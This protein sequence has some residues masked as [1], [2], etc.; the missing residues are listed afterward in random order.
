MTQPA[1]AHPPPH[2]F[3]GRGPARIAKRLFF[4]SRPKFFPASILPVLAGSAWGF[5]ASGSFDG[6]VFAMALAATVC[7]HA[8]ANVLNDVGDDSGGTDRI[9]T[10]RIYPYTGGSRFIQSGILSARDMLRLGAGLL[11]A[12]A[13]LGIGLL[14]L[15]GATVLWFGLAGMLLAVLYSLGPVRLNATGFGEAVVAL[16]FGVIPVTGAA[17]LQSGVVDLPVLL[18]SLPVALW[19]GAILLINEVP[20]RRADGLS[21]KRTLPVRMGLKGTAILY[22]ALQVAAAVPVLWLAFAGVLPPLAPA[23]PLLLL[24]PA[25]RSAA[26]VFA[27]AGDRRRMTRAIETT[28]TVH[29][30][31]TLWLGA[32]VLY[33]GVTS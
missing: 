14:A 5:T 25:L 23:A 17:W 22:G 11:A 26:S 28:L 29:A 3:T 10:E 33:L 21:G 6:M 18:F 20:D 9:N 7:V 32:C 13:V 27:D 2:E 19:V 31:G 30:V 12:A 4:A 1:E 16:A 24:I 15:K 8:G